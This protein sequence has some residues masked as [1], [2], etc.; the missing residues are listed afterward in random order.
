MAAAATPLHAPSKSTSATCSAGA[1]YR[2]EPLHPER[3]GWFF[4]SP[5]SGAIA[6]SPPSPHSHPLAGRGGAPF[7]HLASDFWLLNPHS[8]PLAGRGRLPLPLAG[9]VASATCASW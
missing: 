1:R 9:E 5:R 6:P 2:T 8:H 7:W 4:P 3:G